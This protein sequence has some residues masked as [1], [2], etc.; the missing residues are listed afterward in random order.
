MMY[1]MSIQKEEGKKPFKHQVYPKRGRGQRRQNFGNRDRG[2]SFN[3]YRKDKTLDRCKKDMGIAIVKEVIDKIIMEIIAETEGDK[4]VGEISVM[5]EVD[6]GQ[7]VPHL[8]EI[9]IDYIT[10][11]MQIWG[12]EA[13]QTQE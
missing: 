6:Q 11:Q 12:L 9:V 10:V 7:E 8:G 5:I 13:G 3:D 1:N 4:T 2:R